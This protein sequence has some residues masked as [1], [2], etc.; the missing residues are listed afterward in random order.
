MSD[1]KSGTIHTTTD[2][3]YMKMECSQQLL[4]RV[5]RVFVKKDIHT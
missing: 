2:Y 4:W 3:L 5:N 1:N